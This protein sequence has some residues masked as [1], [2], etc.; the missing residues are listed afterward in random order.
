M[1]YAGGECY[2]PTVCPTNLPKAQL[3][4]IILKLHATLLSSYSSL[5]LSSRAAKWFVSLQSTANSELTVSAKI[6]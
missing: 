3:W 1:L 4:Q 6:V 2:V 5:S